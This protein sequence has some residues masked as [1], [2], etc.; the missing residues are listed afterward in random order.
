MQFMHG[1]MKKTQCNNVKE[2]NSRK[3][4][5]LKLH[6]AV[7]PCIRYLQV[8]CMQMKGEWM[9]VVRYSMTVGKSAKSHP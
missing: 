7:Y 3:A 6:V 5:K 4:V 2:V 1:E 8:A 9:T